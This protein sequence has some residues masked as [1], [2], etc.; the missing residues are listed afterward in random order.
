MWLQF[1]VICNDNHVHVHN[2]MI[3]RLFPHTTQDHPTSPSLDDLLTFS[4][5]KSAFKIEISTKRVIKKKHLPE[6]AL[7]MTHD[8]GSIHQMQNTPGTEKGST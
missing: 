2:L 8:I 5:L 6:R 1:L 4:K 3:S 7:K